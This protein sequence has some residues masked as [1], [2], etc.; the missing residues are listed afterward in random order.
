MRQ[1]LHRNT[2]HLNQVES[3]DIAENFSQILECCK[4]IRTKPDQVNI[5]FET[6]DYK[7]LVCFVQ[8]HKFNDMCK[9]IH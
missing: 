4:V 7:Y 2:V 3:F 1:T 9:M 5:K 6:H 8:N